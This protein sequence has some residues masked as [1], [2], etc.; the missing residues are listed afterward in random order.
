MKKH[1]LFALLLLMAAT[2]QAQS[3]KR[4]SADNYSL[5]IRYLFESD[6]SQALEEFSNEYQA[7]DHYAIPSPALEGYHPN[8]DTVQGVM[9]DHDLVDTVLYAI[10]SYRVSLRRN[11]EEGG[12]VDGGGRYNYNE[13]ATV[14][15]EPNEGFVFKNWTSS[16]EVMSMDAT[17]SFIVTNDIVLTANFIIADAEVHTVTVSPLISHGLVSVDPSGEVEVGNLV[18]ITAIPEE[19]Y[20]LDTLMAFNKDN[21]SETVEI[22]DFTFIMPDF[23]VMISAVFELAYIKPVIEGEIEAPQAICSGGTLELTP[24]RVT[25]AEEEGW[26][27]S[28]SSDFEIVE[29]YNG[30]P[31]D[32]TYNGWKLRYMASNRGGTVYSN[33]VSIT[34]KDMDGLVLSGDLSSCTG[35]ECNYRLV[36]SDN[37]QLTWMVSDGSAIVTEQGNGLRVLWGTKGTQSVSVTAL[38]DETGCSATFEL[39]VTVQSYIEDRDVQNI[40]AKKHDGKDYLLIY[41]NPKDTYKYQWYKDGVAIA[42]ANGQ[43]YYP[44]E[45]LVDGDYQVY[46]SFNADAQ[47]NLF[48]G[49]FSTVYTVGT[50]K[51]SFAIYPNPAKTGEEFVVVNEGDEAEMCVYTLDGK[52]AHRQVVANGRQSINVILPQGVYMVR[53]K[54]GEN[55]AIERI[56]VQ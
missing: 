42:G 28:A 33:V 34:V 51:A 47:G 7:G 17:Y 39:D 41:P 31:L 12:A 14:A 46:I 9:P 15:A 36:G 23:D 2:L 49:A 20:L 48:C 38:D 4:V 3:P 44:V 52:L 54:A 19:G 25:A 10:N 22:E 35:L 26:Q 37:V 45:G 27:M 55:V 56:I 1:L 50:S 8:I 43:Y 29:E 24:P 53:I 32:A 13:E 5:K 16:G 18:T 11:P 40:V 21:V 6:L 30:Q